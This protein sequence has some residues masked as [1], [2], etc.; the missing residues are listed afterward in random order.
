MLATWARVLSYLDVS[1]CDSWLDLKQPANPM[2]LPDTPVVFNCHEQACFTVS[3]ICA[4]FFKLC[5][6][7]HKFNVLNKSV[8]RKYLLVA[9]QTFDTKSNPTVVRVG[10]YKAALM[11]MCKS[12]M[13]TSKPLAY[14]VGGF[15]GVFSSS[16]IGSRAEKIFRLKTIVISSSSLIIINEEST[17]LRLL[18]IEKVR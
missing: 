1:L 18:S 12:L 5:S 16:E 6:I 11:R 7:S 4:V 17:L 3:N 8:A 15:S 14:L 9:R 2:S 13:S 10:R